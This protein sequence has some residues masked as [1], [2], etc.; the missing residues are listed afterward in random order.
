LTRQS[1]Y[2][3][4][5]ATPALLTE[6]AAPAHLAGAAASTLLAGAATSAHLTEGATTALPY[7]GR[8]GAPRPPG[9]AALPLPPGAMPSHWGSRPLKA[10][11]YVGVFGPEVMLC[12]ASVRV[13]RARQAFW[14]VWDREAGALYERTVLRPGAVRLSTGRVVVEDRGMRIDVRLVE[15]DGVEA[16]CRSGEAYAWTR[17]QA[18]A[19]AAG[20][21]QAAGRLMRVSGA[22]IIDDTAAYYERHTHWRWSAGAGRLLDGRAVAWNLVAGVN[23]P[24]VNSERTVWVDGEPRE[25]ERCRF[26]EDLSAVDGLRFSPEAER[27][28]R[29]SLLLLR[30][31]YRQ[32]FGAFSGELPGGLALAEGFGVME[33]HEA[34]W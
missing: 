16:V 4:R 15:R 18:G 10:W 24:P 6:A 23:D 7:R 5:A 13:G 14:A 27:R 25:V 17:K 3:A 31:R 9:L 21:V 11:R 8:F 26:A 12:A 2:L 33:E 1:A 32:P 34:W 30:S 22:A 20:T 28:R 29:E 19:L